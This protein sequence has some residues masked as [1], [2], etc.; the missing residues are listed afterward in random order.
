M[1]GSFYL[2]Y[3]PFKGII[4]SLAVSE[5]SIESCHISVKQ[6]EY[7]VQLKGKMFT[8]PR[9]LPVSFM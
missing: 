2:A 5:C 9:I 4:S 1:L 6:M 7:S 3:A 8:I